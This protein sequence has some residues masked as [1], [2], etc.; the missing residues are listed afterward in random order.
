M[1]VDVKKKITEYDA[2]CNILLAI[3]ERATLDQD[4]EFLQGCDLD[5]CNGF[6]SVKYV[7]SRFPKQHE[8][9]IEDNPCVE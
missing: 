2:Y 9:Q 1:R 5:V 3:I 8:K 6:R 7:H 4:S